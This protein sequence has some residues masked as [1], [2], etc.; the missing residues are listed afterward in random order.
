MATYSAL[1]K[2]VQPRGYV[3]YP[4]TELLHEAAREFYEYQERHPDHKTEAVSVPAE[5]S[6]D[7]EPRYETQ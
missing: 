4:V 7:A 2:A 5:D 3:P 6:S 1:L